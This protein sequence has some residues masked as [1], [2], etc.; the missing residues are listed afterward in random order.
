[1]ISQGSDQHWLRIESFLQTKSCELSWWTSMLG[2]YTW[3]SDV[4][5]IHDWDANLYK[6]KT[7]LPKVCRS[8]PRVIAL[9]PVLR[10]LSSAP[11]KWW[12]HRGTTQPGEIKQASGQVV[13]SI[14]FGCKL[15][16]L[17]LSNK[18]LVV[19][20]GSWFIV[21]IVSSKSVVRRLVVH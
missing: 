8:L 5:R 16:P 14:H 11:G 2:G 13:Q 6:R 18:A 10:H 7:G 21:L 3:L 20:K 1:M 15:G 19:G 12:Y 17:P 4:I 9:P